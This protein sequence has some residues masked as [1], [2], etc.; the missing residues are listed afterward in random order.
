MTPGYDGFVLSINEAK[1]LI[2]NDKEGEIL[3]RPY[4]IGRE[5]LSGNRRPRRFI[6][7]ADEH[8][9]LSLS[10]YNAVN[11][12]LKKK[13]YPAVKLKY[14][15]VC[16]KHSDM[17]KPRAEHLNRWWTFWARRNDLRKWLRYHKR[18]IAS[19][20]TQSWPFVFDFISTVIL[21]GDKLQLFAFVDDYS[22]G[23]IQSLP[24]CLWYKGKGSRLKNE[25]DYNYS[26]RSIF[27]TFPWPQKPTVKQIDAV[28]AAGRE[29]R[30]VREDALTK[31]RGGLRAVY[32]TLELPGKN[33]LRDA[34]AALDDAVLKAF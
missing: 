13:V 28:A 26:S 7:D 16:Q 34:H 17:T 5:L 18:I 12:H 1:E 27:D 22:F 8:D 30:R 33:P 15:Q 23:I 10:Q 6:I 14:M 21:P 31:I 2:A 4:L 9:L 25:V 24:H 20:R 3:I 19:S 32:R 11:E 29:V